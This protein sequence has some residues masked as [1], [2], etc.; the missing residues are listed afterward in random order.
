[1]HPKLWTIPLV[2]LPIYS[3]GFMVMLGFLTGI[4]VATQ[5]AKKK[6]LNPD[7]IFD[8]G[9]ILMIAGIVGARIAYII[10]FTNQFTGS[11]E[12]FNIF[13]EGGLNLIGIIVGWFIPFGIYLWRLKKITLRKFGWL[14]PI[15]I[16]SAVLIGRIAQII[17]NRKLYGYDFSLFEIWKGGL[18]FYGGLILAIATGI[19]YLKIK[20]LRIWLVGD[21]VAPSVALGLAFGRL[22]CFLNG[23]CYG[24]LANDN[25]LGICFPNLAKGGGTLAQHNPVFA[26]QL[27]EGLI[28]SNATCSLS[29]IPTQLYESIFALCLFIFLSFLLKKKLKEG[30]VLWIFVILYSLGRFIIELYRGDKG[31]VFLGL[32]D[33]QTI[34]A[35][36]FIIGLVCFIYFLKRSSPQSTTPQ[37]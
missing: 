9:I 2:N 25:T 17:I 22:G 23:C 18:V 37:S 11:W 31:S 30:L 8:L 15:S 7:I 13:D 28:N 4:L 32:T 24:K 26:S 20:R 1:M 5:R 36:L 29:V 12:I 14:V 33:S 34:S 10:I 3:Y 21:I 27:H 16:L 19:Y 35:G 6:G